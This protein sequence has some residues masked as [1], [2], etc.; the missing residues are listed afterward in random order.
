MA[1][2]YHAGTWASYLEA[3]TLGA[4]TALALPP[5]GGVPILFLTFP[6]FL[7]L[8]SLQSGSNSR[9]A[10]FIGW[11]FGFGFFV[12]G[13]YWIAFSLHV[14][15]QRFFWLIPFAVL[16]IPA[17]LAI[18]I[19]LITLITRFLRVQG[20]S[21][22]LLF[23]VLWT[24]FEWIRG[25]FFFAFPWNLIGYSWDRFPSFLQLAAYVGIY[26]VSLVTVFLA[27]LLNLWDEWKNR[28]LARSL[29]TTAFVLSLI[30]WGIIGSMRLY[31]SAPS[32]FST[33][34]T[35]IRLVQPNIEQKIK[36]RRD[37]AQAQ[38]QHLLKLTTQPA[39]DLWNK[40]PDIIVWPESAVP[41]FL[42]ESQHALN[43]IANVLPDNSIL[44]TGAPRR[45]FGEPK[46]FTLWNSVFAINHQGEIVGVYDKFHLVPFGEYLPLRKLLPTIPKITEGT[47]DYSAAKGP[48][49]LELPG[50][51]PV[52]PLVCFE[53][54]FPSEVTAT[55][56]PRPKWLLNITN[57]AWFGYTSGPFQHF[58]SVRVRAIEEGL[59]LIRVANSGISG[60]IDAYGRVIA[61]LGLNKNG[62]LNVLLPPPIKEQ[63][64]Y[65]RFGDLILVKLIGLL[66]IL[67]LLV[68]RFR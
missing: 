15:L 34:S 62:V 36:W 45:T 14:D 29:M 60:I 17:I 55:Q 40:Q 39:D 68:R 22:C 25:H 61:T 51:P 13:L 6:R 48:Q 31:D 59:P 50:L 38:F 16:G 19:G 2:T 35:M 49:T 18:Y 24:G 7:K 12:A 20:L 26:G 33:K 42:D 32:K 63:T 57:D 28:K 54:I 10:F 8:F 30:I 41:F 47:I 58:A 66:L 3:L 43:I 67:S 44:I 27:T 53:G 5:I 11:W 56:G 1:P 21:R 65:G 52:S 9:Q 4:L 64:F 46:P 37:T 23:A